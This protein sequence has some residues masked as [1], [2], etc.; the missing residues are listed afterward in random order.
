MSGVNYNDTTAKAS[1]GGIGNSSGGS[2]IRIQ[3]STNTSNHDFSNAA[4]A[5]VGSVQCSVT[6]VAPNEVVEISFVG[7]IQQIG[8]T[9]TGHLLGYQI[10][11][12]SAVNTMLIDSNQSG[13]VLNGSFA[14]KVSIASPGSHTIKFMAGERDGGTSR[15]LAAGPTTGAGLFQVTQF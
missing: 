12:D 9:Y 11:S 3:S 15:V 13:I 6:T 5:Q 10:D 7:S 14:V 8:A 2:G 1:T 4:L